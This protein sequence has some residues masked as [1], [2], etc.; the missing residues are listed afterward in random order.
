MRNALLNEDVTEVDLASTLS[1]EQV[2]EACVKAGMSVHPTGIDH[3]TVTVVADHHPYEV[4]TLRH[5][6]E[7]FGR[8]AKVRFTDDWEADA[9]RR[10]FTINALY[11]DAR[12]RIYDFTEGYRDILRKR[13]YRYNELRLS[14]SVPVSG[15]GR[16][17]SAHAFKVGVNYRFGWGGPAASRY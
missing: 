13:G 11:C 14:D 16:D 15:F 12:G 7:T 9:Q 17:A 5:D 6:I 3:G 4:T 8:H 2:T 10:D 1:P